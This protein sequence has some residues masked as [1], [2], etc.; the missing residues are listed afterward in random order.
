M[1]YG[2]LGHVAWDFQNSYGTSKVSSQK[3]IPFLSENFNFRV[4]ELREGNMYGRFGEPPFHESMKHIA[5]ELSME[6]HPQAMGV[7]LKS[8]FGQ[9]TTTSATG[10]QNHEFI[11]RNTADFDDRAVSQ[12]ATIEVNRNVGSAG[13]YYDVVGSRLQLAIANGQLLRLD[14]NGIGAG[15]SRGAPATATYPAHKPF[16]WVQSSVSY[17]AWEVQDL[18]DLRVTLDTPLE[19]IYTLGTSN[20]P[21]RIKRSGFYTVEVAGTLQFAQHS[22][23]LDFENF[24]TRRFFANFVSSDA[25]HVVT[26][27]V[28]RMRF[29]SFNPV[30]AGPGLVQAAFTAKGEFDTNSSY[31]LRVLLVNTETYY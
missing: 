14:W 28:P 4:E 8:V 13:L 17:N 6:A 3:F 18:R 22:F 19:A 31:A 21:F 1:G 30:I 24:A 20:T 27:D 25:P 12:P 7:L 23:W 2:M 16:R 11:P 9:V 15:F 5:A 10:V 26:I 29:N